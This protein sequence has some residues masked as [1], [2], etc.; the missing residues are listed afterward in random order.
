M[1][2]QLSAVSF[3]LEGGAVGRG[4]GDILMCDRDTL[5]T[6]SPEGNCKKIVYTFVPYRKKFFSTFFAGGWL[7]SRVQ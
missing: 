7:T 2:Y 4:G 1:L 5:L 6:S 3:S